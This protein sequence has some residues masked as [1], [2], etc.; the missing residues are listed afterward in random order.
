MVN[1]FESIQMNLISILVL[2]QN[3]GRNNADLQVLKYIIN[4]MAPSSV[5][6]PCFKLRPVSY[7]ETLQ[8]VKSKR[9]DCST[10][11]TIYL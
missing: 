8:E 7:K 4:S 6:K 9:N 5:N 3:D 11:M 10:G 2:H 1:A